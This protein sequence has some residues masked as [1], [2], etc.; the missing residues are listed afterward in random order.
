MARTRVLFLCTQNSAR[1]QMAEALLRKHGGDRFEAY[2]AGCAATDEVH[3]YTVKVM[4]ELVIDIGDQ[5]PKG[6][7]EY[8]GKMHFGYV[9]AVCARAEKECP[10]VFPGA[11]LKLSWLF[12]DPRGPEVLEEEQLEKFREVRD[13]IEAKI[14]HWIEHPEEEIERL[15]AER[16][17]ER[18]ERIRADRIE[19]EN[20][21][22]FVASGAGISDVPEVE[23]VSLAYPIVE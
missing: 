8:M 2:S 11:E 6:M 18:Q 19:A 5:Y 20:R 12:D 22:A 14:L 15:E 7:R 4:D 16:V 10:T 21:N 9:V 17:R 1:S 3:P 23:S 13:R